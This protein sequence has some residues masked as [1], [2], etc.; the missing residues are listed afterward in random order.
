MQFRYPKSD[1]GNRLLRCRTGIA[2]SEFLGGAVPVFFGRS[3]GTPPRD[4]QF[5]RQ[6][7][8]FRVAERVNGVLVIAVRLRIVGML[9]RLAGLLVPGEVILL[10]VLLFRD[11][12]GVLGFVAQFGGA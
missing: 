9:H 6:S 3:L 11:A 4:P 8:D 5:M 12:M 1:L 10:A 7:R 2:G